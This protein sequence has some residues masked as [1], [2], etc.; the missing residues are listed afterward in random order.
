MGLAERVLEGDRRAVARLISLA[1]DREPEAREAVRTLY[2]HTGGAHVVGVTGPPGAGKSTLTDALVDRLREEGETVG[3]VAVDPSSPFTGGAFLGDRVRMGSR[4][5]DPDVF[6]RSM[7][8]RGALGGLSRGVGDAVKIL[9]AYGKDVILVETVGVGQG[10]VDIVETAD[11][12]AL[13]LVP[14]L[15]DDIQTIKAGLMEIGDVFVV[16]KSDRDGAERTHAELE[17]W[18][19][20]AP[21]AD[22]DPPIV[23]TVAPEGRGVDDLLGE[24]RRHR[25]FLG[26]E[27]RLEERRR[28]GA[29]AELLDILRARI[30]GLVLDEAHLRDAFR[31]LAG[32]VA[33]R[34]VD[35]YTAADRVWDDHLSVD[36]PS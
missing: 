35:P 31:G 13:V 9:D 21:A 25:A 5:T 4:S 30:E 23:D 20:L 33:R 17:R 18:L 29:E 28:R 6:I 16:N 7:G 34:E 26:K 22:W 2:P 24:L 1:E 27:G 3:V 15:G 36:P 11:T 10:E 32:E 12:V 8:S 19:E 14:G